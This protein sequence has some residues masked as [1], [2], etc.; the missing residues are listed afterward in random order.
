MKRMWIADKS[1]KTEVAKVRCALVHV[2]ISESLSYGG[3]VTRRGTGKDSRNSFAEI[4]RG[5]N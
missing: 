1:R 4:W 2:P 3:K 5:D